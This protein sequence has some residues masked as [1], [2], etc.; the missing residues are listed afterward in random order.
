MGLG[1]RKYTRFEIDRSLAPPPPIKY[2]IQ[3]GDGWE[4]CPENRELVQTLPL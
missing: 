3:N 4:V 1:L 2:F